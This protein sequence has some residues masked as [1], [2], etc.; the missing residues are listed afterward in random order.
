MQKII[1]KNVRKVDV[2]LDLMQMKVYYNVINAEKI[3]QFVHQRLIVL[4]VLQGIL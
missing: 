4:D 2:Q 3:A 1:L